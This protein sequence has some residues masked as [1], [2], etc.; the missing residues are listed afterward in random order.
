MGD[1]VMAVDD[2]LQMRDLLN[3]FLTRNGYEVI[4]ASNGEDA[5]ELAEK[6]NPQIILLDIKMPGID[7]I[8]VCRRLRADRKTQSIPI[9]MISGLGDHKLEAIEAGADD[10]INKP[11]DMLELSTRI[12]SIIRIRYLTNELERALAYISGT[13]RT[14]LLPLPG[15]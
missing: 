13:G 5:I 4:L 9:I 1:K 2:E 14:D 6:E 7:G 11:I 10:F 3:L 15:F 8:E 12:K